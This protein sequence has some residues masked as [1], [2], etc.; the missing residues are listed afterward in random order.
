MAMVVTQKSAESTPAP[1]RRSGIGDDAARCDELIADPLMCALPVV[2]V[3]ER[4]DSSPES[5]LAER[6]ILPP[7]VEQSVPEG[8]VHLH[9]HVN[10]IEVEHR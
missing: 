3:D 5:G 1:N 10:V 6:C 8:L 2:M 4:I 9:L 7:Y